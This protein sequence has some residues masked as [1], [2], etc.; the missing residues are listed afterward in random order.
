[1]M[2]DGFET[3]FAEKLWEMIPSVYRH[4]DGLG[5]PPDVLRALV[6]VLA[7]QAA[8][9][10][11]SHDRLWDDQFI[12]LCEDW[13]VPYLGD[14]VGTRLVSALNLRGRRVDVAKTI[15]YRRR[16]GTLAVLEE[17]IGD[18]TGWEG[19]VVENFRRLG[20]A[21][22]RLDPQ[23]APLAG[24]FSST[25]PGGWADMRQPRA[26]ELTGSPFDEFH[27]T[28]DVRRHR[29]VQGRYNIP[30]LSF[31]LYRLK[32]FRVTAVTPYNASG[33]AGYTFDPSG[34]D[35]PVFAPHGRPTGWETWRPAREWE[36]PR[37]I[38]CRVLNHAEYEA[39]TL[40]EDCGKYALLLKEPSALQVEERAVG[41]V[42]PELT[43]AGDL[44]SWTAAVSDKRLVIDPERGRFL[45]VGES[46]PLEGFTVTYHYGFSAEIGAGAY[47]RREVE[48]RPSDHIVPPG[49]GD[50]QTSELAG[51]T[52]INDSASY[53]FV[54]AETSV[55][56]LT[57]QAAN[58]QRPYLRLDN[59]WLLTSSIED[60]SLLL[61][62]V[63]IGSDSPANLTL[64][65]DYERVILRHV[66]LDP[67]GERCEDSAG[68]A[69]PAVSLIIEGHVERLEIEAS[70][71]GPIR[72]AGSG[73]VEELL[74]RDS[75][76]QC[77]ET[78]LHALDLGAGVVT[79]QRVTV[80]GSLNV[81]RLW[82]TET[83]LTGPADV[84]D[85]QTGCFRFSAAPAG[86]R[87]PRPYEP[88]WIRDSGHLFVSRRFGHPGFA[89]LSRVAPQ[90]LHR[91]AE[92]GSEI[93]AFSG[94][95]NPI[96]LDSLRAKV[97]EF[98]PF[99][100]IPLFMYET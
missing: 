72:T 4:E 61:D 77:R 41:P 22:H 68:D 26:A 66:T 80:L 2:N 69:L 82:A 91:G 64:N 34:R 16:K 58:Q 37:P 73:V 12:D 75:I 48:E 6:E 67:G 62:G 55:T 79:L 21:R 27:Y 89:Q 84:T 88:Q 39:G 38:R 93:G 23:P 100:L 45:Y 70:I 13:A 59:D 29:G 10:R 36:L 53:A 7:K 92:N 83:L 99:G 32:A 56:S 1:M 31:H 63:W 9:L 95:L 8:I 71:T 20:R 98:M 43:V 42:A 97:D 52:Q 85:T 87:L 65:G 28:P 46:P 18:M 96:K 74:V 24:R 40:A 47:D 54:G 81:H 15:Y 50:V 94:L 76:I 35:I 86:S 17:L 14:L 19:T 90:A 49:G 44:L 51:I 57:V 30:K 33:E 25:P 3:Y 78:M 5:T 11:R 60:A